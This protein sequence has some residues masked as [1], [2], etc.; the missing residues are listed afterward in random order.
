MVFWFDFGDWWFKE[1]YEGIFVVVKME[2]FNWD[3]LELN[4]FF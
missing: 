1:E 3:M 2:N 4:G